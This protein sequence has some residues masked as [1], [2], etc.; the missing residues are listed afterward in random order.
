MTFQLRFSVRKRENT[1]CGWCRKARLK[2][3]EFTARA[4]GE[5]HHPH[6]ILF[7]IK[8][9]KFSSIFSFY[10]KS[11]PTS[12]KYIFFFLEKYRE[13]SLNLTRKEETAQYSWKLKRALESRRD[14]RTNVNNRK[15]KRHFLKCIADEILKIILN[16]PSWIYYISI[17]ISNKI[18]I[19][20]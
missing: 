3:R 12:L 11:F 4:E 14:I 16:W 2:K 6:N 13:A 5:P 8:W 19:K 17:F 15:R 7:Y 18:W 10:I 9:K 1:V 20:N